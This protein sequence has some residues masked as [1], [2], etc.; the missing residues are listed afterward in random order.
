MLRLGEEIRKLVVKMLSN[1]MGAHQG[2]LKANKDKLNHRFDIFYDYQVEVHSLVT[3]WT[4]L[5]G[6]PDVSEDV[7]I[8]LGDQTSKLLATIEVFKSS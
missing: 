1:T 6:K 8:A 4:S 2:Q 7:V 5:K 3:E